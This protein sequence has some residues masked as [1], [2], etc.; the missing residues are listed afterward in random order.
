MV[1]VA[2]AC[3]K[4]LSLGA[5]WIE[6]SNKNSLIPRSELMRTITVKISEDTY[7]DVHALAARSGT[8]VS[9]IA[10]C[11]L[12]ALSTGK[13]AARTLP[14]AHQPAENAH[15]ARVNPPVS[16]KSK[17]EACVFRTV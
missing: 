1:L 14:K 8:S 12:Q 17:K 2:G 3:R 10:Q 15:S 13:Q 11:L 5:L 9:A 4:L 6:R 7:C 16:L